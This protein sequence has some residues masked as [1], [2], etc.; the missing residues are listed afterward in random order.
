[1]LTQEEADRIV[2]LLSHDEWEYVQQGMEI[3]ETL[4]ESEEDFKQVISALIALPPKPSPSQLSQLETSPKGFSLLDV[5]I[6]IIQ[7]VICLM[8]PPKPEPVIPQ[9]EISGK[10]DY[11]DYLRSLKHIHFCEEI[12]TWSFVLWSQWNEELRQC[13]SLIVFGR[14]LEVPEG[15]RR[16]V[17]LRQIKFVGI[18]EIPECLRDF[19][20][21][22]RLEFFNNPVSVLPEWLFEMSNL[23][24][25]DCSKTSLSLVPES[26]SK[27]RHLEYLNL[28][29]NNLHYLP[30][31]L[32]Q[33]KNLREL[34]LSY[35]K[36]L[37][38]P[39]MLEMVL[40]MKQ[41]CTLSIEGLNGWKYGG[42]LDRYFGNNDSPFHRIEIPFFKRKEFFT[43]RM[44]QCIV[45]IE[46]EWS[47]MH[48]NPVFPPV[49][50]IKK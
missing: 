44:P 3:A 41:L 15:L 5:I 7:Y 17:N 26:I 38:I 16:F 37:H 18:R 35:N 8:K 48:I 29:S 30:E 19:S 13:T 10:M 27:L 6:Q 36:N 24:Y 40:Q 1:M 22:Q 20:H 23:R 34:R 46:D 45:L 31:A 28:S 32:L 25:L 43:E 11:H 50:P 42:E 49:T 9:I 12:S 39:Q 14:Y 33:L 2:E 21:L 47:H 4:M